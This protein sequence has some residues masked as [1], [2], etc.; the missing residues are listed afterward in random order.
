VL[1][2]LLPHVFFLLRFAADFQRYTPVFTGFLTVYTHASSSACF[3]KEHATA[4]T[5]LQQSSEHTSACVSMRQQA[6]GVSF[7]TSLR[8][9]I[10]PSSSFPTLRFISV[11]V[12]NC[13]MYTSTMSY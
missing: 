8:F 6:K 7:R 9:F 1:E 2:G 13:V 3:A 5:E 4:A 10:P 12:F 11:H